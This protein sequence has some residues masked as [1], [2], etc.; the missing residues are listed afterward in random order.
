[1]INLEIKNNFISIVTLG[2]FNPAILNKVFLEENN[3]I[4]FEEE[5]KVNFTPIVCT[6]DYR[7]LKIIVD[8]GRFQIVENNIKDFES[9]SI[10]NF[11]YNY[12][13]VLKYTPINIMGINFN[14]NMNIGNL[15][16]I[17]SSGMCKKINESFNAKSCIFSITKLIEDN[18]ET[19][20]RINFGFDLLKSRSLNI[21][22]EM[23]EENLSVVNFNF[24][25]KGIK[26]DNR[27]YLKDNF[28]EILN[29]HN[30]FKNIL[31]KGTLQ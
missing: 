15:N 28:K 26:K 20:K 23:I 14:F 6:I 7:N 17:Y 24:E 25:I 10:L 1:M 16:E 19:I 3:I 21:L 30:N 11:V 13:E 8:L 29:Y 18:K 22:I 27:F 31:Q 9:N 2:H 5:P 12:L 4:K